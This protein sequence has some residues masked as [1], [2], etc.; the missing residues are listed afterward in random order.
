MVDREL[1]ELMDR[2]EDGIRLEVG[3]VDGV[4]STSGEF[5]CVDCEGIGGVYDML[6]NGVRTRGGTVKVQKVEQVRYY[7]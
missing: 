7:G 5:R 2:L 1:C 3:F 4:L 6:L